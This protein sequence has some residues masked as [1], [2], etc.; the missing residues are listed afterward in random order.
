[1][2]KAQLVALA[3]SL[4]GVKDS[5]HAQARA[6]RVI[7]TIVEVVT[8]SSPLSLAPTYQASQERTARLLLVWS[9]YES[10]WYVSAV[11][12]AG[13]SLGL[14]QVNRH[15]ARYLGYSPKEITGNA[16]VALQLGLYEM[17]R[18]SRECSS[19]HKGLGAYAGRECGDAQYLVWRRCKVAGAC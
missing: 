15:R 5:S 4:P 18:L 12:D 9:F 8:E 17:R 14:L 19:I 10:G 1:M 2:M 3:L 7:D 11:G 13:E 6:E 16:K